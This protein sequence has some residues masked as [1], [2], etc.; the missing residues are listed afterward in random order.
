MITT[1]ILLI[2]ILLIVIVKNVKDIRKS[3]SPELHLENNRF[4]AK[5]LDFCCVQ[6]II[7]Q[8]FENEEISITTDGF[9]KTLTFNGLLADEIEDDNKLRFYEVFLRVNLKK[10][11]IKYKDGL[12]YLTPNRGLFRNS[13]RFELEITVDQSAYELFSL[14]G[15][16]I[17]QNLESNLCKDLKF[18]I[19]G[20]TGLD[21]TIEKFLISTISGFEW[22]SWSDLKLYDE[23]AKR[24]NNANNYNEI[25]HLD[26]CLKQRRKTIFNSID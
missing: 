22:K 16:M 3:I 9:D 1:A 15:K 17:S 23:L 4:V 10:S 8:N 7:V 13:E 21:S 11:P 24:I 19:V 20:N 26:R 12:G 2:I 25:E 14:Y 18:A 5:S 6:N